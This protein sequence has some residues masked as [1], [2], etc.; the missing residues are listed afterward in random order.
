MNVSLSGVLI[1]AA[2]RCRTARDWQ[3]K[4]LASGLEDLLQNL[5]C[6][7]DDP[8]RLQEFFDKWVGNQSTASQ[9]ER[10]P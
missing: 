3:T 9:T 10:T 6:V 5:E 2:D 1:R 7:R 8:S 4:Q